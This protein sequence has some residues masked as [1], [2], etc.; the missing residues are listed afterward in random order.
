MIS[1]RGRREGEPSKEPTRRD[2]FLIGVAFDGFFVNLCLLSIIASFFT[3]RN[4]RLAYE[5]V[6]KSSCVVFEG[7]KRG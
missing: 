5:V 6:I 2:T 7:E 3:R 4:S 1:R